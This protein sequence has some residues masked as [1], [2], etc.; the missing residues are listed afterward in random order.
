MSLSLQHMKRQEDCHLQTRKCALTSTLTLDFSASQTVRH[1]CCLS[2]S[3]YSIV[4]IIVAWTKTKLKNDPLGV[5]IV[6]QGKRIQLGTMR[7]WVRSLALPGIAM[8]CG[9]SRRCSLNLALQ[10]QLGSAMWLWC[11]PAARALIGPPYAAGV[12]LK[13]KKEWSSGWILPSS[14]SRQLCQPGALYINS[15]PEALGW[16]NKPSVDITKKGLTLKLGLLVT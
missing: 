7:L 2:Y 5:P 10:M 14:P 8:S 11:S 1:V 3:T 9:V 15:I 16:W 13:K 12:A 6:A 4:I